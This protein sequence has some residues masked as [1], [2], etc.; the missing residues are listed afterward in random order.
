[1][2]DFK[3]S[4]T[5]YGKDTKDEDGDSTKS[6]SEVARLFETNEGIWALLGSLAFVCGGVYMFF[7]G[8]SLFEKAIGIL[9]IGFFGLC[10]IATA[11]EFLSPGKLQAIADRNKS[12]AQVGTAVCWGL[13]V[14]GVF[15]FFVWWG[16]LG[17]MKSPAARTADEVKALKEEVQELRKDLKQ[18]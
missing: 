5:I 15:W 16:S 11:I 8:D 6:A 12:V 3:A 2:A 9:C 18:R 7:Y 10:G 14:L 17:P 4:E 13:I 1:M